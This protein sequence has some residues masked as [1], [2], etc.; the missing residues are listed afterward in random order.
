M[1]APVSGQPVEALCKKLVALPTA[2][3]SDVLAAMGL[4]GQVLASSIRAVGPPNAF[5]GPALCLLGREGD[6]PANLPNGS[7]PVFETDRRITPGCV[8]V[9]AT[10]GHKV[11]AVIGGNVALSWRLRGCVGVVTDGGI[12]DAEECNQMGLP[13]I[14][15]FVG[16]MSNKGLWAFCEIDVQISLPGQRGVLVEV[17]PGDIIHSDADG[18]LVI[19]A[20][21]LAQV[22]H[23]GEIVEQMEARIRADLQRGDDREAVYARHNR[24]AHIRKL[25][26]R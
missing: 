21:H 9:I 16:P 24:F 23:D 7:K 18:V 14:A 19:P 25:T 12:R 4:A 8:A 22:V 17:R 26:Q 5:A 20:I 11:G 3:I 1:H 10:G 6:E 2:V 13:V 15:T